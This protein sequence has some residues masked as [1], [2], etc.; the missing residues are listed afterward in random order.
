M[1]SAASRSA[2]ALTRGGGVEF[3]QAAGIYALGQP[4]GA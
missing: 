4:P 3:N 2:T 1:R